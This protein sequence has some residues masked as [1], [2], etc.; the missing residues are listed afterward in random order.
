MSVSISILSMSISASISLSFYI[1]HLLICRSI[2]G[3]GM[4]CWFS[5]FFEVCFLHFGFGVFF[6]FCMVCCLLFGFGVG[7]LVPQHH[8]TSFKS[9]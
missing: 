7:F 8:A 5:L 1:Y 3:F 6:G 4:L 9:G 2:F